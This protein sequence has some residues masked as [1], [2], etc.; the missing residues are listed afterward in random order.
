MW[1][2]ILTTIC[3]ACDTTCLYVSLLI[4]NGAYKFVGEEGGRPDS[5]IRVQERLT[6]L[7]PAG[8]P[9][10]DRRSHGRNIELTRNSSSL[11]KFQIHLY[12]TVFQTIT[13]TALRKNNFGIQHQDMECEGRVR[14][15]LAIIVLVFALL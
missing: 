11:T 8:Q 6:P 9:D 3:N 4:S 15:Y 13:D 1:T 5:S 7:I 10:E 2:R 12:C 14:Q